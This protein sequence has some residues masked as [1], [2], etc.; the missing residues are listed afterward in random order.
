MNRKSRLCIP[1]VLFGLLAVLLATL[2][3]VRY[4]RHGVEREMHLFFYQ[5]GRVLSLS[6]DV[7]ANDMIANMRV[8]HPI[9]NPHE[10]RLAFLDPDFQT[11]PEKTYRNPLSKH[12][13][14]LVVARYGVVTHPVPIHSVYHKPGEPVWFILDS[15]PSRQPPQWQATRQADHWRYAIT[16]FPYDVSNGLYSVGYLYVDSM[17]CT[18]GKMP[19]NV[20]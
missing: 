11:L 18:L 10:N 6:Q 9:D 16:S 19:G 8:P 4:S 7:D 2:I 14:E 13:S 12:G 17:G 1:I 20:Y 5:A 15:G 3:Y